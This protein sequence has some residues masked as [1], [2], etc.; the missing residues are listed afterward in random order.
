MLVHAQSLESAKGHNNDKRA[1]GIKSNVHGLSF[2]VLDESHL[3]TFL[4]NDAIVFG[5]DDLG[6]G[7][8]VAVNTCDGQTNQRNILGDV[9]CKVMAKELYSVDKFMDLTGDSSYNELAVK[10]LN[11]T[12][13]PSY[14]VSFKENPSK[15]EIEIAKMYKI[16]I[17]V[18]EKERYRQEQSQNRNGKINYKKHWHEERSGRFIE[19][20]TYQD[21]QIEEEAYVSNEEKHI[22]VKEI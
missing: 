2:S 3:T 5:Y 22:G 19:K 4:S 20:K 11:G 18:I 1:G 6:G 9:D 12:M 10:F 14:V 21:H 16:P 8:I 15:E 13:Q 7:N 17:L